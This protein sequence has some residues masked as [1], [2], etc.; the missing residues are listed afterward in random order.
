M[1]V[2]KAADCTTSPLYIFILC[3][4][5]LI[6]NIYI[7]FYSVDNAGCGGGCIAGIVIGVLALLV[8]GGIAIVQLV[9]L[10]TNSIII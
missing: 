2:F 7:L 10:I 3:D 4:T 1:K 8:G 6:K 5:C 9:L